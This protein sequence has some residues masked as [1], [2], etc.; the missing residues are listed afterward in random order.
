MSTSSEG[1]GGDQSPPANENHTAQDITGEGET[2]EAETGTLAGTSSEKTGT[3]EE[4][5]AETEKKIA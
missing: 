1:R 2:G 5:V 3:S 4:S